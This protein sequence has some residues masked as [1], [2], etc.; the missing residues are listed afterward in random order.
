MWYGKDASK[1]VN[2]TETPVICYGTDAT[3]QDLETETPVSS[4]D[5]KFI[6]PEDVIRYRTVNKSSSI[7]DIRTIK[8]NPKRSLEYIQEF[9]ESLTNINLHIIKF[10]WLHN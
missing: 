4:E 2:K 1:Q 3:E 8:Y 10:N 9:G 5:A 6:E 7:S